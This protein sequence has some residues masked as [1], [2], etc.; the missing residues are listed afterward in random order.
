MLGLCRYPL[1]RSIATVVIV[2][3]RNSSLDEIPTAWHHKASLIAEL[4][5][6][7]RASTPLN[8]LFLLVM[9]NS[10]PAILSFSLPNNPI[11]ILPP[12]SKKAQW[13]TIN[14]YIDK[15]SSDGLP[16][17]DRIIL[18]NV[19]KSVLTAV[20]AKKRSKLD[21]LYSEANSPR[22]KP[23]THRHRKRSS[24]LSFPN[25]DIAAHAP[26]HRRTLAV[27]NTPHLNL[28]IPVSTPAASLPQSDPSHRPHRNTITELVST[29]R[30]PHIESSSDSVPAQTPKVPH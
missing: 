16:P 14:S 8:T 19:K 22:A 2:Q 11:T 25:Y 15:L 13:D 3:Q 23:S 17:A 20:L 24:I 26:G 27:D 18:D 4:L 10:T 9:S 5:P 21:V 30:I 6:L 1:W 29:Q 28:S 7:S 12:T